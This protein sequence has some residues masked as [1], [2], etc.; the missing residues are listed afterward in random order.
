M[1]L[2]D[3]ISGSVINKLSG[4]HAPKVQAALDML[5]QHGGLPGVLAKFSDA[6]FSKQVD[7]W[8]GDGTNLPLT[9]AQVKKALGDETLADIGEKFDLR[10]KEV[11]VLL[12]DYLPRVV[13][14]LTHDGKVPQS[15]SALMMRAVSLLK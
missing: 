4:E 10:S 2:F 15:Q 14:K 8:I 9:A 12:A 13:D 3:R 7:S 11:A 6:G 5:G 1:G